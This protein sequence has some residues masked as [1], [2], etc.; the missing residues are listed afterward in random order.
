MSY[1]GVCAPSVFPDPFILGAGAGGLPSLLPCVFFVFV[2]RLALF[3]FSALVF[4][5]T[6]ALALQCGQLLI[7][8][9]LFMLEPA[10]GLKI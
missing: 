6:T 5:D 10:V 9:S 1:F 4:W 2:F 8:L 7:V 3:L